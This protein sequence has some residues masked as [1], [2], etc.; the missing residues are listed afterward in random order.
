MEKIRTYLRHG[1]E[2]Q[3][4]AQ[5]AVAGLLGLLGFAP[6]LRHYGVA[7]QILRDLGFTRLRLLTNNPRKIAELAGFSE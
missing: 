1:E 5:Q 3:M 7:A 6:D 2:A 4:P